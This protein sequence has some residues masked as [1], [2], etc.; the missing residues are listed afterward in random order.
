MP[1]GQKK[2]NKR[3]R[4]FKKKTFCPLPPPIKNKGGCL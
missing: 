3:V 4:R 1:Q 2:K